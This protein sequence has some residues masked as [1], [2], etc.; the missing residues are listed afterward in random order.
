[1]R[2]A[3]GIRWFS[4]YGFVWAL[5]P[6]FL[7][8][9]VAVMLANPLGGPYAPCASGVMCSIYPSA[10]VY[11]LLVIHVTVLAGTLYG[12]GVEK[13]Y[14]RYAVMWL[15]SRALVF[16]VKEIVIIVNSWAPL[17]LAILAVVTGYY[18]GVLTEPSTLVSVT[19]VLLGS[20]LFTVLWT[21]IAS[22]VSALIGRA[23]VSI[24]A[25]IMYLIMFEDLGGASP[26]T[27]LGL[28]NLFM[29]SILALYFGVHK[30]LAQFTPLIWVSLSLYAVALIITYVREV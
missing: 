12:Y 8:A 4:S 5:A 28:R 26:F 18:Q 23:S 25:L 15:P 29:R 22:A 20:L 17:A 2:L 11:S 14:D 21:G 13:R 6:V 3:G 27:G 9:Y 24:A 30:M 16:L 19:A 1:M 10:I 7:L